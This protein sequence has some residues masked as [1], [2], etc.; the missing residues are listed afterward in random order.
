MSFESSMRLNWTPAKQPVD[1]MQ[2][3]SR[4]QLSGAGERAAFWLPWP[5]RPPMRKLRASARASWRTRVTSRRRTSRSSGPR[6]P[7][8]AVVQGWFWPRPSP[9]RSPLPMAAR[10]MLVLAG[11]SNATCSFFGAIRNA[12]P[13]AIRRETPACT[14]P[15]NRPCMGGGQR[16]EIDR[17]PSSTLMPT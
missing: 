12:A 2:G 4:D 3:A 15:L 5:I 1:Q 13:A 14:M 6:Q 9:N 10:A 16:W 11:C 17:Q 8:R 7:A